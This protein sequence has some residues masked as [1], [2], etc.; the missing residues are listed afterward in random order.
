MMHSKANI[1]G[2]RGV[3]LPLATSSLYREELNC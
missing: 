3:G 2:G 1:Q